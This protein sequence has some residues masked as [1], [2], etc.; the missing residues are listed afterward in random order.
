MK[1]I[2]IKLDAVKVEYEERIKKREKEVQRE[3]YLKDEAFKEKEE[4][5][6]T[7]KMEIIQLKKDLSKAIADGQRIDPEKVAL[8]KLKDENEIT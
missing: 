3:H 4:S 8:A 6:L 7:L 5:I 2:E 1:K